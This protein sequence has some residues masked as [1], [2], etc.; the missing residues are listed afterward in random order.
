MMISSPWLR[1]PLTVSSWLLLSTV[2]L[3]LSPVGLLVAGA[4][5]VVARDRRPLILARVLLA[6]F[7]RELVTL[8][9]CG[10]IWLVTGAGRLMHTRRVEEWHWRLLASFVQGV[11]GSTR[12]AL[13]IEVAEDASMEADAALRGT[14]PLIVFSRHAGPADTM[15]L[16]DR[17]L[18]CF[19]RRPSV[20]FKQAIALDPSVDLL[21]HR[22]P[23][24]VLDPDDGPACERRIETTT[25]ELEARG[26]LVLFP[27]GGNFT[28]ERRRRAISHLRRKG[29]D[30]VAETADQL[31]HVLPPR[32]LG[33]LA[34]LHARS[35]ADVIFAAHTG[36]GLAAYP[37]EIWR[38][39]PVGRTLRTRMWLVPRVEV[40]EG[41]DEQARWLTA[42]WRRIDEWIDAQGV[43]PR[44]A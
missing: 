32:P 10:G 40:P 17:L 2:A 9:A 30:E 8:L 13:G 22:L 39:M 3:V 18:A 4:I 11:A 7:A 37:R 33:A 29:H 25:R 27:E 20:V 28:P 5:S 23:H 6:Y 15:L 36:L 41:P 38:Q 24:A 42:W 44:A 35:D 31:T 26:V 43:E 12:G 1:R 21:A 16:I 34:A 19:H 14:G